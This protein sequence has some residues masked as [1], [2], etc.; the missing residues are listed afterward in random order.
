MG[1]GPAL[2]VEC[3]R[4]LPSSCV[5]THRTRTILHWGTH[6]R[7]HTGSARLHQAKDGQM[8]LT[9]NGAL[10]T[11]VVLCVWSRLA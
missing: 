7:Q 11:S 5:Y 4:V 8:R 9:H 6:T 10:H 1:L 3:P 2:T